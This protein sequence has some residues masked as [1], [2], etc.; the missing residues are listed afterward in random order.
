MVQ[1]RTT[2]CT[3]HRICKQ[4]DVYNYGQI[5]TQSQK[6]A[7]QGIN[8]FDRFMRMQLVHQATLRGINI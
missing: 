5:I 8:Y 4:F 3:H 1:S 6:Q 7:K 2:S